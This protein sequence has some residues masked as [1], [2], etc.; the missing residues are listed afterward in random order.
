MKKWNVSSTS[1]NIR[2]LD[3]LMKTSVGIGEDEGNSSDKGEETM[4]LFFSCFYD[5][6]E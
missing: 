2:K 1:P 3:I 4:V 6:Y 5:S